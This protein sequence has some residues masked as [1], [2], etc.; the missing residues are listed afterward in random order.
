M[1]LWSCAPYLI[2]T[3]L[4]V[5]AWTGY[6]ITFPVPVFPVDDAYIVIHNAQVLISG[7]DPNYLG[8][9]P[10]TG[11]T[12]AVHLA[13]VTTLMRVLS[14]LEA[15]AASLWISILLYGL[16]LVRLARVNGLSRTTSVLVGV[17]GLIA[18]Q[19]LH[20]LVNGLETGLM[21]ASVT[22]AL[23]L[24]SGPSQ[25]QSRFLAALCGTLPFI[26]PDLLPLALLFLGLQ[27]VHHW[28]Q[29]RDRSEFRR[30]AGRDIGIAC[31]FALPWSLWNWRE[32]GSVFPSTMNAKR[33]F[34]AEAHLPY[35]FKAAIVAG[36]VSEF[37]T[38][39]GFITVFAL[40][41]VTTKL[42][43]AGLLYTGILLLAY[44]AQFPHG[45]A[46]YE[47]RYL[48]PLL[49]FILLGTVYAL[50]QPNSHLRR[51][52]GFIFA[53]SLGQSL[54]NA[55]KI[56]AQ[57]RSGCD[58]TT[59]DLKGVANWCNQNLP[60]SATLLVHDAGYISYGTRLHLVDFVGLKTPSSI[61]VHR[62][63]TYPSNGKNR[64]QAISE[65][66]LTGH[67]N[68]LVVL[69]G[70]DRVFSVVTGLRKSGWKLRQVNSDYRYKVYAITPPANKI[71]AVTNLK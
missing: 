48:Y 39:L 3:L 7:S 36:H 55:P 50:R 24:L 41:L 28:K 5:L 10:L 30:L 53:L 33:F 4:I 15:L 45:L 66:G 11:T 52:S 13:L 62:D 1:P 23:A 58:F 34:F 63:L 44:Y 32:V 59:H 22:W 29:S 27:A 60:A 71:S 25:T 43:R 21:L 57:N 68:Y 69:D 26:R 65:I 38:C 40:F 42:G 35:G 14:P 17:L 46:Q 6:K 12:S 9:S 31:L 64:S 18:G 37:V 20:Q 56:W 47:G 8:A 16:G 67:A 70:W 51:L 19:A 2:I 61:V 49:P 54:V